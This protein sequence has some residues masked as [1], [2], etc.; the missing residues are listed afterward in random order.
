MNAPTG[1]SSSMGYGTIA[2]YTGA[3]MIVLYAGARGRNHL[4]INAC[5]PTAG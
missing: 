2:D 1:Y 3:G 5:G 4:R